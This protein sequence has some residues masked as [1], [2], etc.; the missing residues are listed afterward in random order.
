MAHIGPA[1]VSCPEIHGFGI[2]EIRSVSNDAA[3]FRFKKLSRTVSGMIVDDHHF[4]GTGRVLANAFEKQLIVPDLIVDGDDHAQH[5]VPVPSGFT[6]NLNS[7]FQS[8]TV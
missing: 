8:N 6:A 2:A 3:S 5:A 4:V 7:S 1:R